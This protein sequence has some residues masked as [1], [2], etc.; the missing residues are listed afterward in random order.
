M[1][2]VS[3]VIPSH[4]R[5]ALLP[6]AIRS[7]LEQT[8][9]PLEIIV[10]DDGSTD[11]TERVLAE[12]EVPNL[13][14]LKQSSSTGAA[15]ARN[16]G[17]EEARGELIGFLDSDDRWLPK[18][19]E[20]Q[21]TLFDTDSDVGVVYGRHSAVDFTGRTKISEGA[22]YRGD[23]RQRLLEGWCP[24]TTSL[25]VVRRKEL[26]RV[27][28]FDPQLRSFHDYDLWLRLAEHTRFDYVDQPIAEFIF[29]KGPRVSLDPDHRLNALEEFLRKWRTPITHALGPDGFRRFRANT[30]SANLRRIG[31]EALTRGQMFHGRKIIVRAL[32][33]KLLDG[34]AFVHLMASFLG[35]SG[36]AALHK[37]VRRISE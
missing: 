17:I 29:H 31:I 12:M 7:A 33:E 32:G 18:K 2:T 25:F 24:A 30:R 28:G 20:L 36:Y 5:A 13:R 26:M 6:R 8:Q 3:V 37:L 35:N 22:L 19:L 23:I 21:C 16:R 9:P 4:N 27:G 14:Y 34:R 10:V 15:A 11:D 1:R